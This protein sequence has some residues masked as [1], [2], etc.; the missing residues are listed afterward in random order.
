M[1]MEKK[2]FKFKRTVAIA[3]AFAMAFT[4]S[5]VIAP[6][7]DAQAKEGK[8]AFLSDN[9]AMSKSVEK[10]L[11]EEAS[12]LPAKVD[13]RDYDKD[14]DGKGENYVTPVKFQNPF[15][16]CWAF[17]IQSAA[18]I[19][20]LF[21]NNLGTPAGTKN[22][23]IDLSEKDFAW[24]FYHGITN[25]DVKSGIIPSS[26][27]GEGFD[28]SEIEKDNKNACYDFGATTLNCGSNFFMSGQGP[29]KETDIVKGWVENYGAVDDQPYQYKGM[30][31]WINTDKNESDEAKAA[32]KEYDY[33][34]FYNLYSTNDPQ[35]LAMMKQFGY[36]DGMDFK[37]WFDSVYEEKLLP[38]SYDDIE[39]YAKFDDWRLPVNAEYRLGGGRLLMKESRIM[40]TPIGTKMGLF[41]NNEDTRWSIKNELKNGHGVVLSYYADQS[42]PGD[43]LGDKGYMNTT[44]WAQY[45][46]DYKQANHAVCVVGYDDNY[47]K[48]NF[49]R[50]VG[51]KTVEGSTP[52]EDGAFII[53]NSWGSLD[54]QVARDWGIDGTGYF[55]LSYFDTSVSGAES[56][57]FYSEKEQKA[58]GETTIAQYDLLPA[59]TYMSMDEIGAKA[60]P[61][62][63]SMM[64]NVF[65]SEQSTNL[66]SIG[67][68][69][70]TPGTY[71]DYAIY[72]NLK[73]PSDPLSGTKVTEGMEIFL[74]AGY[75]RI[76]LKKDIPVKKGEKYSVVISEHYKDDDKNS[77]VYKE[78]IPLGVG[79][80]PL[81]I[82]GVINPG[83]SFISNG[84]GWV[85]ISTLRESIIGTLWGSN[86]D[87]MK[88]TFGESFT[89]D[90]F[91][92]DNFPIKAFGHKANASIKIKSKDAVKKSVTLKVKKSKVNKKAQKFTVKVSPKA[93]LSL[94]LVSTPKKGKKMLTIKSTTITLKKK[95]PAGKYKFRIAAK[96]TSSSKKTTT[97]TITVVVK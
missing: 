90:S 46:N 78:L 8:I 60:D 27:V 61:T 68:A 71:V 20:Y 2:V 42:R 62:Q 54:G 84:E 67:M 89:K 53:K 52:P 35:M 43:V 6:T 94:S 69:T 47:P 45:T 50:T 76:E 51:G 79:V 17:G 34:E 1:L 93:K 15:G 66:Y 36:K 11:K 65:T 12:V 73:D 92:I 80:A 55:Y 85:D 14:G 86:E 18:E 29:K 63:K 82:K 31:G 4:A 56:Y 5:G 30:H 70:N 28:P 39:S 64:A 24:Y 48:E 25:D 40:Q 83:E 33:K 74:Y 9:K 44:N 23:K 19:S 16:T 95:A 37:E 81:K 87:G 58:I 72:T 13:L 88:M 3:L 38:G 91:Q 10:Q 59:N 96:E 7:V 21:E 97:K 77:D 26:Q 49:T 75:Q 57:C 22:E 41:T 32:R